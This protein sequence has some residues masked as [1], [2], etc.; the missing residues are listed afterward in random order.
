MSNTIKNE[1]EPSYVSHPGETLLDILEEKCMSQ[2]ELSDRMGYTTK[3]IN[4]IIKGKAPITH[5][6]ALKLEKVFQTPASFWYNRQSNYDDYMARKKEEELLESSIQWLKKF[7]ISE[8]IKKKYIESSKD[9]KAL[10]DSLLRFFGVA[11]ADA[12][13]TYWGEFQA[14]FRKPKVVD[15]YALSAWLRQGEIITSTIDCG[16]Y[17]K[18]EFKK[19]LPEIRALTLSSS[20]EYIDRKLRECCA[21]TGVKFAFVPELPKTASGATRWLTKKTPLIQLSLRYKYEDQIWFSFFHEA[22]HVLLHNKNDIFI[23]GDSDSSI[24]EQDADKFATEMLI[25]QKKVDTFISSP[26]RITK[27]SIVDF[28]QSMNIAPGIVVGRLQH[29]NVILYSHYNDLRKKFMWS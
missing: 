13:E 1:Y 12:W 8:M 3:H 18:E 19:T 4:E 9:T 26:S 15:D 21:R 20:G 6:F 14:Q 7:P 22:A 25:P 2:K 28:A 23:N 17:N 27:R 11:T 10:L 16:D 29:M 24:E 5:E